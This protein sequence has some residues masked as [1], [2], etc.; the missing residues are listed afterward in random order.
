[1]DLSE[2]ITKLPRSPEGHW[3]LG[4][5][6]IVRYV[7]Q[8]IFDNTP[9]P[10]MMEIGLNNGTS[11]SMWL[12][13]CKNI[14]CFQSIDIGIHSFVDTVATLLELKFPHQFK[15]KKMDSRDLLNPETK[16][17]IYDLIF[18]DGGHKHDVCLSDL[19]F[20]SKHARYILLDDTGGNS[21]GVTSALKDP[22]CPKLKLLKEWRIGAGCRLY[23]NEST[24]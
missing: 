13:E 19:K 4:H 20:T 3:G 1:M 7:K 10:T 18:I 11:A 16:W 2:W 9:A 6:P 15:F 21:P 5:L 17:P 8:E 22:G 23:K 12:F 14:F 24:D